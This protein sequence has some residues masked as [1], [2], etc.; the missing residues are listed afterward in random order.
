MG[1]RFLG[2][3]PGSPLEMY[4][5]AQAYQE[6]KLAYAISI[7]KSQ[8]SEWEDVILAL[9][10]GFPG[11]LTRKLLYTAF[12]R[13]KKRLTVIANPASIQQAMKYRE[14]DKPVKTRLGW[15]LEKQRI[16]EYEG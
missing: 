4:S 9:P 2:K 7:H 14:S 13:A 8:G 1:I 11:F 15:M 10:T 6:L 12:S 16:Q 5:K 3:A